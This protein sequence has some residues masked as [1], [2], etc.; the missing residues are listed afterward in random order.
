M[1]PRYGQSSGILR[2]ISGDSQIGSLLQPICY[3]LEGTTIYKMKKTK[4]QM[5]WNKEYYYCKQKSNTKSETEKL[6]YWLC[7]VHKA[8]AKI[9]LSEVNT[10][11]H[12]SMTNFDHL[13][14]NYV[15]Q[16]LNFK[17]GCLEIWKEW[18]NGILCAWTF[19]ESLCNSLV[20]IERK[21]S[22]KTSPH[23]VQWVPPYINKSRQKSVPR[24]KYRDI[25][26]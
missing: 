17:L 15:Q 13:R 25:S 18:I 20:Y 11:I 7:R 24:L 2:K 21:T 19:H 1:H 5:N 3:V 8:K 10:V 22:P 14:F 23:W 9:P 16:E 6:R 12:A 26:F 4:H